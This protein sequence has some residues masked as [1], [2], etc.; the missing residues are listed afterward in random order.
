MSSFVIDKMCELIKRGTR[1]NKVLK[2]VHLT[3]MA[4]TVLK[5][6]GA[7]VS[8]TQVYNHLGKWR[9]RWLT[10]SRFRYLSKAK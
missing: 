6:S 7:D 8:F 3:T 2:E 1:T 10:I 9:V 5:Q 4:K